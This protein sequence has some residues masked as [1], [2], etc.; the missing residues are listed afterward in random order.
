MS[1][2]I[3]TAAL[4]L[5]LV[6]GVYLAASPVEA[7]NMGFKLER[8]FSTNQTLPGRYYVSFPLF[9]GL[10]NVANSGNV[11]DVANPDGVCGI[12]VSGPDAVINAHDAICDMWI[13]R[14]NAMTLTR[15]DEETCL[16]ASEALS[17]NFL[18]QVA[19]TSTWTDAL[20]AEDAYQVGVPYNS[21]TMTEVSNRAVIVGSHDPN[22]PMGYIGAEVKLPASACAPNFKFINLPYHTMYQTADEVLCGLKGVDWFDDTPADG[23]PDSCPNGIFHVGAANSQGGISVLTFDNIAD[24]NGTDGLFVNRSVVKDFLGNLSFTG[25]DFALTPGDGY[26]L[27]LTPTHLATTMWIS[28]HF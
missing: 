18:G 9:N 7:S 22:Y 5:V 25:D 27:R 24:L 15:F 17:L 10:G 11:A 16:F 8:D 13:S 19:A 14:D 6:G 3:F 20:V 21:T 1:R 4:A 2:K 12:G 28:P 26:L 23:F